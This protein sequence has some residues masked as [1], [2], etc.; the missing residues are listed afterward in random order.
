MLAF[1]CSGV[2]F[3]ICPF[4]D[5]GGT[6]ENEELFHCD[7]LALLFGDGMSSILRRAGGTWIDSG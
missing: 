3:I 4:A 2:T 7:L 1:A 6:V 5:M